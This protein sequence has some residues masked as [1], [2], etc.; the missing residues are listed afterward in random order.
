M[1][2]EVPRFTGRRTE[3]SRAPPRRQADVVDLWGQPSRSTS[4]SRTSQGWAWCP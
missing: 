3:S 2:A 1:P 4:S